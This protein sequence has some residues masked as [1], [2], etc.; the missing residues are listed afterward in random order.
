MNPYRLGLCRIF[1]KQ[2]FLRDE[3]LLLLKKEHNN[4]EGVPSYRGLFYFSELEIVLVV[5]MGL[6]SQIDIAVGKRDFV[7]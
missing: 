1:V 2:S 6:I 5:N 4:T 7:F 3:H